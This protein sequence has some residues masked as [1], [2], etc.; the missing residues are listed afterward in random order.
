MPIPGTKRVKYLEDNAGAVDVELTA[1]DLRADRGRA[2]AGSRRAL[3]RDRDGLGR[4]VVGHAGAAERIGSAIIWRGQ[5]CP[6]QRFTPMP[7]APDLA[8]RALDGRYELHALIGEG[9]FGRVYR[10]SPAAR[11]PGRRQG[12]QALVGR[13][14]GVGASASSARRSCWRASA[15]RGSCR[16]ST[17]VHAEEGPYYVVGTGRGREP[18]E[19]LRR[20]P[21]EAVPR[22]PAVAEQL[23]SGARRARTTSG[24]STATSS[25]PTC[26]IA[27]RRPGQGLRLRRCA[28]RRG[29]HRQAS[30]TV[31]GTPRYMSPEQAPA[32]PTTPATDVY[33]AGVVLY[34][35]LAGRRRSMGPAVELLHRHST[36]AAPL[37]AHVPPALRDRR[38]GAREG[39][40]RAVRRRRRDGTRARPS[41]CRDRRA[42]TCRPRPRDR[43]GGRRRAARPAAGGARH[44]LS[45]PSRPR[46]APEDPD[47]SPPSRR[48]GSAHP[49]GAVVSTRSHI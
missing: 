19:R 47:P 30:A 22:L 11:A 4:P 41:P 49:R 46:P 38:Q 7:R 10:G 31:A 35:M 3:R 28:A 36:T 8:G 12:D 34:E 45:P 27:Y 48:S 21:F 13:G 5:P 6:L 24:S 26:C 44:H 39:S 18:R 43:G 17:S 25:R 23:C 9:A 16:S 15:T 29:K 20:G 42:G 32:R 40:G 1:D 2:A 33:S 37:P 14:P